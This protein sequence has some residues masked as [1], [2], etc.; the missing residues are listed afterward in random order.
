MM[1]A[2]QTNQSIRKLA[3]TAVGLF[4]FA[5]LATLPPAPHASGQRAAAANQQPT[6]ANP[7]DA[8]TG[9]HAATRLHLDPG[10]ATATKEMLWRVKQVD[11]LEPWQSTHPYLYTAPGF[12]A[13]LRRPVVLFDENGRP[14]SPSLGAD[15]VYNLSDP[16]PL[17]RGDK[18]PVTPH[19][20]DGVSNYLGNQTELQTPAHGQERRQQTHQQAINASL[21]APPP[22]ANERSMAVAVYEAMVER[23][24]NAIRSILFSVQQ[25]CENTSTNH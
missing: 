25:A 13:W 18:I 8:S 24:K 11:E 19:S 16:T 1:H 5:L 15:V 10:N 21:D 14:F 6:V 23:K 9:V 22:D 12:S 4:S 2:L 3:A 20:P 7:I 17:L